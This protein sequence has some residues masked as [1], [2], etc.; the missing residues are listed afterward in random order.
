V[1][2][3]LTYVN[4]PAV[5][6]A[7]IRIGNTDG[8]KVWL[9]DELKFTL[10]TTRNAGLEQNTIPVSLTEG[11]NK[12]LLKIA[13]NGTEAWGFYLRITDVEGNPI[14][15]FQYERPTVSYIHNQ[16]IANAHLAS[17]LDAQDDHRRCLAAHQLAYVGDKRGNEM[18]FQLL[19]SRD[20]TIRAKSAY[21]LT[22]LGDP[23][24]FG[25]LVESAL[26]QDHL[27][28]VAA[29]NALRRAGDERGEQFSIANLKNKDGESILEIKIR[30]K[31]ENGFIVTTMFEGDETAHVNVD[32][33]REFHLG[34]SVSAKYATIASFGI[35]EPRYRAMG[36]GGIAINRALEL[37]A[38]QGYS[39][40]TVSTGIGLVAHRLYIQKGYV[41]RRFPWEYERELKEQDTIEAHGKIRIREYTDAD[42]EDIGRLWKR[43]M[44]NT[45][46]PG[47]WPS[48]NRFGP[49]LRIAEADGKVIGFANVQFDPFESSA[50]VNYVIVDADFPD[51]PTAVR[52]MIADVQ[53]YA[54][55]EG[56][57]NLSFPTPPMRHRD[58]LRGM[59]Y[60]IDH[61]SLR[62]RWVNMFKIIDLP[63]F[64][65]EISSL[66]S[67]RLKRSMHA[68]WAGSIGIKGSS[69]EATLVIDSDGNVNIEDTVAD[70]VDML[71]IADDGR[72]T[73]LVSGDGEI[74]VWYR[75][76]II[77]VKPIF[78]ERSRNLI[79][80]L[81]PV[82][83]CRQGG[84]W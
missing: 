43:Y 47:G 18:L 74:W 83:D 38:E 27:F 16:M 1:A 65:G 24:G 3:A 51:E 50:S 59:D 75:H 61:T 56:K 29:G 32:S 73:S 64:L 17:L 12:I 78:N 30:D 44:A 10:D 22:L 15:G 39:C 68:G 58:I 26:E 77:T 42:R 84:W 72:I 81:F 76:N 7:Q 82:M 35:R 69:L 40:T 80:T 49:W 4:A 8:I 11:R 23:R 21:A 79:E 33:N 31:K 70:N 19:Q 2:Y 55:A 36:L 63:K 41:D 60:K 13:N 14:P 28:Q 25:P 5:M 48:W 37:M 54:M 52:A 45:A 66:L 71:I 46:G 57:K 53:R 34:D 6:E 20:E 62:R 9:D 67:L